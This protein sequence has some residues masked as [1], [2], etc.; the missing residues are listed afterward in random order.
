MSTKKQAPETNNTL[1]PAQQIA[2][3]ADKLRDTSAL[4]LTFAGNVYEKERGEL[5]QQMAMEMM[6]LAT[7]DQ[8]TDFEPLRAPVFA[9]ATPF[10]VGDAAVI[11]Q[12]GR[13]LLQQRADN[14]LW[15]MPGGGL[16]VG[17]T[18]SAG[19]VRETLEE[20]GVHCTATGMVGVFDSYR[21][22]T[23]SRHHMYHFV[24]LCQP[25]DLPRVEQP[26][27][28][29]EVLAIA[30]FT[31]AEL[32]ANLDPGHAMRIPIAFQVWRGERG[33]YFD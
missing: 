32:P 31:E 15:A 28:G 19:V 4:A 24:F 3:W 25:L 33:V 26:S 14:H 23:V 11:D 12:T 18:P 17:E 1:P 20:T 22:G 9:H 27:H 13:I 30:W 6:A 8:L 29:H 2:R 10:S 5:L 7:G 21:W 16:E